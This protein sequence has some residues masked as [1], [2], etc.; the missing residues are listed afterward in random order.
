M[1]N[2]YQKWS[3][4]SD[5]KYREIIKLFSLDVSAQTTSEITGISRPSINKIFL[6]IR[7][8]ISNYCKQ[9]S[10]FEKGEI[11][12]DESYFGAKRGLQS[13]FIKVSWHQ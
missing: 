12:L 13:P 6:E 10:I 1:S 8:I 4:F 2:K 7:T 11:E 9:D 3:H 5:R